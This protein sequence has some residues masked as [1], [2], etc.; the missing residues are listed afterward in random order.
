M[1][2]ITSIP[3]KRGEFVAREAGRGVLSSGSPI[4]LV[5]TPPE[6]QRVRLTHLSIGASAG[7]FLTGVRVTFG[8]VIVLSNASISGEDPSSGRV[9]IGEYQP[10]AAGNP[11]YGNHKYITGKTDEA[12][13]ITRAGAGSYALYYAYEF[14]E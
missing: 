14:G 2:N 10:Y 1:K 13:S 11:P 7:G 4:N 12:L 5:V 6:G 3:I 9:S 8:A